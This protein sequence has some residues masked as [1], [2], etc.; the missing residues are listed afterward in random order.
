MPSI[1]QTIQSLL[2]YGIDNSLL[3]KEDE[4]Y[5]RNRL[6]SV[7][8][9]SEWVESEPLEGRSTIHEILDTILDIAEEKG[10]ISNTMT[11]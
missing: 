11:E 2:Q 1:Y 10:S 8:D 5:T 3:P 7:L 4:I 6:M 9:L